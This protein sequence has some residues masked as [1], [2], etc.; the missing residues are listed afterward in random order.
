MAAAKKRAKISYSDPHVPAFLLKRDCYLDLQSVIL[1]AEG[2]ADYDC[3]VQATDHD[4]FSMPCCKCM[5]PCW[6]IRGG[7]SLVVA[8]WFWPRLRIHMLVSREFE[9]L[10]RIH[11]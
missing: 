9:E 10:L 7:V 6:W 3:V 5:S 11:R 8:V 2:I 4:K 1:T